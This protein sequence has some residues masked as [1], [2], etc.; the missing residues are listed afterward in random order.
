[1][2]RQFNDNVTGFLY[3]KFGMSREECERYYKGLKELQ[4]WTG[5][6]LM[7]SIVMHVFG[8]V[9]LGTL[10][11][12]VAF[13]AVGMYDVIMGATGYIRIVWPREGRAEKRNKQGGNKND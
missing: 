11:G 7:Y 10:N 6:A 2:K 1:M 12:K 9:N 13:M 8:I 3:E 5:V 4:Y